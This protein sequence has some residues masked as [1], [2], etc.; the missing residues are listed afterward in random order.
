MNSTFW[1]TP[2]EG[3]VAPVEDKENTYNNEKFVYEIT[4][5]T[6]PVAKL[7]VSSHPSVTT[8]KLGNGIPQSWKEFTKENIDIPRLISQTSNPLQNIGSWERMTLSRAEISERINILANHAGLKV[9]PRGITDQGIGDTSSEA[10]IRIVHAIALVIEKNSTASLKNKNRHVSSE[11]KVKM[12]RIVNML[13]NKSDVIESITSNSYV[14]PSPTIAVRFY[15]LAT[16]YGVEEINNII[17]DLY[18]EV[19]KE[20]VDSILGTKE[21]I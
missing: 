19:Y 6:S 2:G 13:E 4:H 11:R 16:L 15:S 14:E 21:M 5:D 10:I 9:T 1:I 17:N 20:N 18:Y 7:L 3:V 8:V 12:N